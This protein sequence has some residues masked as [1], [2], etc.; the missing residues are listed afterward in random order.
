L[1]P[2]LTDS[3]RRAEYIRTMGPEL[4]LLYHELEEEVDWLQQKW[5]EFGEL[6]G[7]GPERIELLTNAASNFFFL[8]HKLMFEDAMLHLCRLT[9]PAETRIR[10]G[11]EV[12]VRKNLTVMGLAD[13]IS[14]STL[15]DRVQIQARQVKKNC[16]FARGLRN[17][18]LAH[19][20]LESFRNGIAGPKVLSKHVEDA[21]KSMRHLLGG[22]SQHYGYPPSFLA[23]DPFGARSL[24]YYLEKAA[25]VVNR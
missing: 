14:D 11:K 6:F 12:K 21:L 19:A 4:G 1:K 20:D 13:A 7:K 24:V 10:V 18:R 5:N 2:N 8:L 25:R 23:K 22:I 15:K 3:E 17:S 16:E 9:D